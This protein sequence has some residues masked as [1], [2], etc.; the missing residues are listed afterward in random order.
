MKKTMLLSA[1]LM[2]AALWCAPAQAIVA[3]LPPKANLTRP[4][5]PP[6]FACTPG[7]FSVVIEDAG[8]HLHGKLQVPTS[9]FTYTIEDVEPGPDGSIHAALH[10][11]AP[12][13]AAGQV[14]SQLDIDYLFKDPGDRL[15]LD[16]DGPGKLAGT[17]IDCSSSTGAVQ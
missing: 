14:V 11:I 2:A 6:A 5:A 10:V 15:T 4:E 17:K 9:G 8:L 13:G 3:K 7:E 16:V 1:A 12:Q